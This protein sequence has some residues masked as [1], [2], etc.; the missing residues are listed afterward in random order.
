MMRKFLLAGILTALLLVMP[1][2]SQAATDQEIVASFQQF[3]TEQLTPIYETYKGNHYSIIGPHV[4]PDSKKQK[5]FKSKDDLD[6]K[7]SLDVEKTNSLVSPYIG[8]LVIKRN[9]FYSESF[10]SYESAEAATAIRH[11]NTRTYTFKIA[12]QNGKWVLKQYGS[13]DTLF[14]NK[15]NGWTDTDRSLSYYLNCGSNVRK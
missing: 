1:Y 7:Y 2:P 12:Y 6:K 8:T 10:L 13:Q 14:D 11:T 5:W 15:F 4:Y 9:D 3:I